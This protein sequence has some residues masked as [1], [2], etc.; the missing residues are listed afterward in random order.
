MK[1]ERVPGCSDVVHL[2]AVR[3]LTIRLI[4]ALGVASEAV[5][6]YIE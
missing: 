5:E 2:G 6:R 3:Q 1:K 4:D